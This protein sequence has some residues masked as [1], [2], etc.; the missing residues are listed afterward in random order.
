M[1][2]PRSLRGELRA[3][4][5]ACALLIGMGM[6]SEPA[7]AQDAAPQ[8][9]AATI[10]QQQQADAA[11]PAPPATAATTTPT[12][13]PEDDPNDP[14]EGFNR[15]MF[16]VNEALDEYALRPAAKAYRWALPDFAQTGIRNVLW[17]L[18]SP[19][20][21]A[22]KLLQADFEGAGVAVGRF[23]I[24]ST[25]GLGGLIDVAGD[26]GLPY[27]YESL[28]Q[29]FAVWGIPEGFYLVVPLLGPSTLRDAAGFG[30]EAWADPVSRYLDNT[31]AD[32]A[33][34]TRGAVTVVDTRAQYLDALDDLKRNSVDYYAAMRSLYRQRQNN[35]IRN[36]KP[37]P[38]QYPEIPDYDDKNTKDGKA[39]K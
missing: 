8:Q 22:N 15:D 11:Q 35:L 13:Q 23:L 21:L 12:V 7:R 2:Q 32:W 17:N 26:H 29:T 34:Y 18:R 6:L 9:E 19:V 10:P 20:T 3:L 1:P 39:A 4:G 31:H 16:S 14:L 37:D 33:M 28:D 36:G 5:A 24:N 30:L 25:V 27:E 38:A